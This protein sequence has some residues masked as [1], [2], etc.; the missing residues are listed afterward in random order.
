MMYEATLESLQQHLVPA[1]FHDAKF[2][3]F[4]HWGPFS[5]P[6]W[7]PRTK[8]DFTNPTWPANNAYAE[9][10]LN[11]M[12]IPGSATERHHKETYGAGYPYERFGATFREGAAGWDP[13]GWAALF[14]AA[15]ARYAIPTTK[16]LDG[17]LMWPSGLPNPHRAGWQLE[18]DVI[19]DLGAAVRGRGMRFGLYYSG[20]M[21]CTFG[22]LPI[23]SL[24]AALRAI[25]QTEDYARYADAHWRELIERYRP[26]V[27][28][29]DIG[30]PQVGNFNEIFADYY[31]AQPD[32]VVNN[33]FDMLGAH[34]GRVHHD[35]FT[36]EYDTSKEI[37]LKKWEACRGIGNSFGFNRNE[38]EE[39]YVSGREL[40]QSLA[41][42]VS[43]NGNL[44][45]NV[46]PTASGEI[47]WPQA[48]RLLEIG[49]WLRVN[50]E[51]IYGT[52]PWHTA[53]AVTPE[54]NQVRFTA[55]ADA[56]YAIVFDPGEA[57]SITIPGIEA[58]SGTAVRH[59][60][61]LDEARVER[62]TGGLR[63]ALPPGPATSRQRA[64]PWRMRRCSAGTT[65]ST[66]ATCTA[67]GSW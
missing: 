51:A 53:E 62:T 43:K 17:F 24:A 44:L 35:F 1:W 65:T 15:G 22:G 33:R 29:N 25:P 16:H 48:A 12:S 30:W 36:P 11:T 67:S 20:G 37:K 55:G 5:V 4:V 39:D 56:L 3:I 21:D 63:V 8:V 2:G 54:G 28:W 42:I 32:G 34:A 66:E 61:R 60:G 10:Y 26:D 46:G 50:G 14:Q 59:L 19:G 23:D 31:N 13:E 47:P 57:A 9:W 58:A 40:I 38:T 52:R 45:L 41:D 6:A 27:L 18:R 7:A 49:Q 64:F